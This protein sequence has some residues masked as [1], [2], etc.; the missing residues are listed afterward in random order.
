MSDEPENPGVEFPPDAIEP[1][2]WRL[3]GVGAY[4]S[5]VDVVSQAAYYDV[6]AQ[7][8]SFRHQTLR[9]AQ[10]ALALEKTLQRLVTLKDGPRDDAYRTQK[11]DAWHEAR[12]LLERRRSGDA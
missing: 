5:D 4:G 2:A 3:K 10:R 6:A 9:W 12:S 7:N 8:T 11:E 1:R